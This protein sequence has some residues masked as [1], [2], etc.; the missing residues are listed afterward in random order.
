M[1]HSPSYNDVFTRE[2]QTA[3][4]NRDT[5][6][7]DKEITAI[8]RQISEGISGADQQAMYARLHICLALLDALVNC[9]ETVSFMTD[10]INL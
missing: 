5:A 4:R 7:L 1:L 3:Y 6:V 9:G 2:L 8:C 10:V